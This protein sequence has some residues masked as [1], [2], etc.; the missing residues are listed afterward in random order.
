M[1]YL[2]KQSTKKLYWNSYLNVKLE[3]LGG[4]PLHIQ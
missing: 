4:H 3:V 2:K 1:L